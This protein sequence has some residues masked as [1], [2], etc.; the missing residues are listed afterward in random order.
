MNRLFTIA[1]TI[2][3][4]LPTVFLALLLSLGAWGLLEGMIRKP[5]ASSTVLGPGSESAQ[6]DESFV[7][8]P[9]NIPEQGG[10]A[11]FKLVSRQEKHTY[12]EGWSGEIRNL[13]VL[14]PGVEKANW[15]FPDQSLALVS[16]VE[17]SGKGGPFKALSIQAQKAAS[18]KSKNRGTTVCIW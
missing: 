3:T 14:N 10:V 15:L 1:R 5:S 16:I 17:L 18:S 13:L 2:N 12:A 8:R 6:Q 7:L 4:L 9:A 11:F